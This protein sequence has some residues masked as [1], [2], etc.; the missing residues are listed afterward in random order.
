MGISMRLLFRQV[1][2]SYT[3]RL[4]FPVRSPEA[5]LGKLVVGTHETGDFLAQLS[6]HAPLNRELGEAQA[7]ILSPYRLAPIAAFASSSTSAKSRTRILA[8][9]QIVA[10]R[11]RST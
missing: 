2:H 9:R 8:S 7:A 11:S 10:G 4:Q 5:R 1:K 3:L 6:A